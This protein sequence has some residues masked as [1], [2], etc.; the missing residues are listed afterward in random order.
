[1]V[2]SVSVG[3]PTRIYLQLAIIVLD[4]VHR[5]PSDFRPELDLLCHL[6][7]ERWNFN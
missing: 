6:L 1:M 7:D 5:R 3:F 4:D 2:C